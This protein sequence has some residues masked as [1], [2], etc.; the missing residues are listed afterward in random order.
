MNDLVEKMGVSDEDLENMGNE[1]ENLMG[2]QRRKR[3]RL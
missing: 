3:R 2:Q 1:L